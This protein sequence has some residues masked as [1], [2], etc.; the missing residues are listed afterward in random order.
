MDL[1]LLVVHFVTAGFNQPECL[2]QELFRHPLPVTFL[3]RK[4]LESSGMVGVAH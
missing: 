2:G 3:F 4:L 1:P